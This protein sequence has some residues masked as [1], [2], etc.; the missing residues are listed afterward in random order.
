[1]AGGP[2]RLIHEL[3]G[4][5][6]E[7]VN[8]LKVE[9]RMKKS[10]L[11]FENDTISTRNRNGAWNPPAKGSPIVLG[12]ELVLS[13]RL[14]KDTAERLTASKTMLRAVMAQAQASSKREV[15]SAALLRI[16]GCIQFETKTCKALRSYMNHSYRAAGVAAKIYRWRS[17]KASLTF[18]M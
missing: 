1:M 3:V 10:L 12:K 15:F 11:A 18:L 13:L 7:V 8:V 2:S 4:A 6:D 17:E 16:N 14:R 5:L 9:A